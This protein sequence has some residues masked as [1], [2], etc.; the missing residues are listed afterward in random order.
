M[1]NDARRRRAATAAIAVVV[2]STAAAAAAAPKGH[3]AAAQQ[4]QYDKKVT[5]CHHTGSQTNPTVTIVVSSHAVP[6][7]L[8]HG[9]TLGP[10]RS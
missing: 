10:C 3:D 1:G 6:A 9:D 4:Y 7:H 2:G 5:I 8:A